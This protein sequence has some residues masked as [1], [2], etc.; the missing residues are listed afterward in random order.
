MCLEVRTY[1]G[2]LLSA[3]QAVM[4]FTNG[5]TRA[6]FEEQ[7]AERA[8]RTQEDRGLNPIQCDQIWQNFPTLT[9]FSRSLAIFKQLI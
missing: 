9:N 6:G 4:Y 7:L 5:C 8:L 1:V 3:D 2:G